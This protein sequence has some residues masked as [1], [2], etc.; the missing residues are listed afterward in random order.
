[1]KI[2]DTAGKEH[3]YSSQDIYAGLKD[4]ARKYSLISVD[5]IFLGFRGVPYREIFCLGD[6]KY[7]SK[8]LIL[9]VGLL[10][11]PESGKSSKQILKIALENKMYEFIEPNVEAKSG[12]K[13]RHCIKSTLESHD[14]YEH[15]LHHRRMPRQIWTGREH[16]GKI[17]L[18]QGLIDEELKEIGLSVD[19]IVQLILD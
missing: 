4:H 19:S 2:I 16:P 15:K 5:Y 7:I 10:K 17:N 18:C 14:A 13:F 12:S 8:D 1:M 6:P 3:E 9:P 11:N